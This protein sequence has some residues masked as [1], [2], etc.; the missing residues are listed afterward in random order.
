MSDQTVLEP[1]GTRP[2][3]A[4]SSRGLR[5][6]FGFVALLVLPG[7]A[8]FL[9]IVAYPLVA[10]IVSGF[11]RQS[12]VTPG[13]SFVGLRNFRAVLDGDFWP[14]LERTVVFTAGTTALSFVL[15][16]GL[17]LALNTGIR[18]RAV[19]RGVF[20]LPWVMPSVVVSFLW[21]WI[22][23]AN[24]GVLNGVLL[25]LHLIDHSVAWLARPGTAMIAVIVA[26]SWASFPWMMVMLLAGLQTVPGELYEAAAMDGAGAVRR[27]FSLTVPHLRPIAGIVLL[28]E[29]IWNFQHFDTI[30]VLTGGG[31]AKATTTLA[32]DLYQT[33]FT[34]FDVGRAGA[35]GALWMVILLVLT[36]GYVWLSER[37]ASR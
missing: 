7:L 6:D 23:N 1:G 29:F 11:F 15:G 19:L 5:G 24:Y 16:L 31:P 27:F 20:L 8:L 28:L 34:G 36:A 13:R 14:A 37:G 30:Y 17:A 18:G 26:K 25:D 9:A 22:F 33:A 12:L 4:A 3:G 10:S 32:V 35:L 21:L 2:A